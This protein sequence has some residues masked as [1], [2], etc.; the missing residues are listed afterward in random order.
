MNNPQDPS[1]ACQVF[2]LAADDALA[3]RTVDPGWSGSAHGRD[4]A[5][6]A[7]WLSRFA[8]YRR[9]LRSVGE[10]LRA[11]DELRDRLTAMLQRDRGARGS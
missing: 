6:C 5:A 4:C 7:A 8:S 11:P 1:A 2:R 10:A 3:A 9:R